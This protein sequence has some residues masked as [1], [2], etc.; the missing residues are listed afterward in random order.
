MRG[1]FKF[2]GPRVMAAG[3]TATDVRASG[4]L[5][6]GRITIDARAAAYGGSGTARGFIAPPVG[7]SP[8]R[9]DLRGS[10]AGVDLR[11]LPA[12]TGAPELQ[13][14]YLFRNITLPVTAPSSAVTRCWRNPPWK[15]RT[16]AQGTTADFRIAPEGI[17]YAARGHVADLNLQRLGHAF[18]DCR[19]GQTGVREPSEWR[20]RREGVGSA[21]LARCVSLTIG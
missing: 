21:H 13:P 18:E 12:Q 10:A 3:Y 4:G 2:E 16:V 20:L 14:S 7:G 5:S 17:S 1:T 19:V 9:F 15:G 11:N 8:L 6:G